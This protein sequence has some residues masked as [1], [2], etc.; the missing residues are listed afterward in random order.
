MDARQV[1][2][3]CEALKVA[4][5][6]TK[7]GM[8]VSFAIHPED[9]PAELALLPVGTRVMLAVARIGDD[10]QPEPAAPQRAPQSV[11]DPIDPEDAERSS[12][13]A[14]SFRRLDPAKQAMASERARAAFHDD[15]PEGQ[16]VK[17]AGM[18][19]KDLTY[20]CWLASRFANLGAHYTLE[21]IREWQHMDIGV[22]SCSEIATDPEAFRRWQ[23]HKLAYDQAT[24]RAA[25]PR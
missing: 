6:Q 2:I 12:A 10:E 9:L 11:T 7:D 3:S 13:K 4:Y 8:V 24:G 21:D 20:Q 5:R 16:A 1:A 25:V 19:R 23:A 18:L 22:T 17:L 14:A 15:T